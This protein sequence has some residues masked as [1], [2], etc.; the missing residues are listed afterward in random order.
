MLLNRRKAK[1]TILTRIHHHKTMNNIET[2]ILQEA[3][4]INTPPG[5]PSQDNPPQLK[6]SLAPS[7]TV[8]QKGADLRPAVVRTRSHSRGG[9]SR[10]ISREPTPRESLESE[11]GRAKSSSNAP[12]SVISIPSGRLRF[13]LSIPDHLP[14]SPLCPTNPKHPSSGQGICPLHGRRRSPSPISGIE[15]RVTSE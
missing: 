15:I 9:R 2:D 14:T 5:E 12:P 1:S 13:T 8:S 7:V 6:C 3:K 10:L 4:R 11:K